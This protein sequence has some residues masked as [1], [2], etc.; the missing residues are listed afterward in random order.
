MTTQYTVPS[1]D[2]STREYQESQHGLQLGGIYFPIL[3]TQASALNH[4]RYNMGGNH[5]HPYYLLGFI[6]GWL[7]W[8]S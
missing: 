1:A 4:C 5:V 7:C 6:P 8:K 3:W 2:L